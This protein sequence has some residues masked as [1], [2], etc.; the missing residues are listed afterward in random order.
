MDD[1][2]EEFDKENRPSSMREKLA[3]YRKEKPVKTSATNVKPFKLQKSSEIPVGSRKSEQRMLSRFGVKN[4]ST[5]SDDSNRK[6]STRLKP[7]DGDN[8]SQLRVRPPLE[9]LDHNQYA[10]FS[11]LPQSLNKS[12]KLREKPSKPPKLSN[13]LH[14]QQLSSQSSVVEHA[15]PSQWHEELRS[16]KIKREELMKEN[17]G[18]LQNI[19][20]LQN[21]MNEMKAALDRCQKELESE[22]AKYASAVEEVTEAIREGERHR[23]NALAYKNL[24]EKKDKLLF[25]TLKQCDELKKIVSPSA[26]IFGASNLRNE[27][28]R[29]LHTTE[30]AIGDVRLDQEGYDE[31]LTNMKL[32]LEKEANKA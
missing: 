13:S 11:P 32:Q 29:G 6:S 4:G 30:Q 15:L 12:E 31:Q 5:L 14:L 20:D 24:V 25:D 8:N 23:T 9:P 18:Y 26:F 7:N 28:A 10:E 2:E 16:E 21:E 19:G 3:A 27:E 1:Y 22:K 17:R